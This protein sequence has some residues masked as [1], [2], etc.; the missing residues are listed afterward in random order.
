VGVFEFDAVAEVAVSLVKSRL[1][2]LRQLRLAQTYG[3]GAFGSTASAGVSASGTQ[4]G[5]V[6]RGRTCLKLIITS[7]SYNQKAHYGQRKRKP[8]SHEFGHDCEPPLSVF[9]AIFKA[10][11]SVPYR[12]SANSRSERHQQ[13]IHILRTDGRCGLA[14]IAHKE[15]ES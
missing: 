8:D 10:T 5:G 7:K 9:S 4:A 11:F 6:A 2:Q 13:P 14:R 3:C 12:E 1:T 15:G